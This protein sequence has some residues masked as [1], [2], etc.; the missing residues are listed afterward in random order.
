MPALSRSAFALLLALT[1][2]VCGKTS[3]DSLTWHAHVGSQPRFAA[4]H[5]RAA[6]L[7]GY[8]GYGLEAWAYPFQLFTHLHLQIV[9][10]DTSAPIDAD[11]L[12]RRI[13]Y[14]PDEIVR[15]YAGPDYEIRERLFVPLDRPG[16]I[17]SYDVQSPRPL[18]LHITFLPVLDLMWP[19]ALGGQDLH[20]NDS[21]RG[22]VI[23][24]TTTGF[25]AVIASPQAVDHTAV[26]NATL[27]QDL[28]QSM[29]LRPAGGHAEIFA[30][31][32]SEPASEGSALLTL[33]QDESQL[34]AA[35]RAQI[36]QL[37]STGLQIHTP[38][39]AL[40][41]ALIWSR[42]ALDEAWVCNER[43]GCG[44]VAGYGP[45]RPERRPQYDWF[46]AGDGLVATEGLLAAGDLARAHDELA[47]I[48]RYQNSANGMIWHEISQSAGFLDWASKYPYMYVHV[49][50]TYQFL[51]TL[52]DYYAATGDAAFLRDHWQ[53]IDAAY[54]YGRSL[55]D[56]QTALPK[57]PPDKEGG[58]EQ[59][60]MSEDVSLSAA[61]VAA[62]AA[63]HALA[64]AAGH[65]DEAAAAAAPAGA[66][67]RALT[68]RYWDPQKNFWISG[69]A[70]SGAPITDERTHPGLL[71][72]GY[73]SPDRED[74]A[75]DRLASS[76][77][78]TDWGTRGLAST[79]S[80]YDPRSYGAGSVSPL[81]TAENAGAF[82]RAHRP[83]IAESI[84]DSIL[85]WLQIDS[86]GHLHELADG[87]RF[88][89][90]VE[91]VPEQTWSSAGFLDVTV[92]GLFGLEVDAAHHELTL[93]P[94]L[95]PRWDQVS[96][97]Q[98]P[99]GP[100]QVCAAINQQAAE[101]DVAF[102]AQ[103][104][105][106]HIV[107]APEIPLGATGV[108]A[109]IDGRTAPVILEAHTEDEHARVA[110]DLAPGTARVRILFTGGLRVRV[111]EVEPARGDASRGL[112]LI[113]LHLDGRSLTL[114]A[115]IAA[116]DHASMEIQTPR[117]I[118]SVRGG[119]AMRLDGDWYRVTFDPPPAS[120]QHVCTRRSLTV[121]FP[122]R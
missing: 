38:D 48:L 20:W 25:R 89:P 45:S 4:A 109:F 43:I 22:Y 61:W 57:I 7:M 32:E 30:A 5:G 29:A 73:F 58:N 18:D 3:P 36:A 51:S 24:E 37:L 79:S 46:F 116:P 82:F 72:N 54:R 121:V 42:L 102:T 78:E 63:Y 26:V 105:P 8:T 104:A 60:R 10:R 34:R 16:V 68:A 90:Q 69:F 84:F 83:A 107:F 120:T 97:A 23:S 103:T 62:S 93:A 21:L 27:R 117:S 94:H 81:L 114:N 33:E 115:N 88:Q 31:L 17:L 99:V 53:Q 19:G 59:D 55:V 77:F 122:G 39:D 80:R 71:A 92:R 110:F 70:A 85:P 74:A 15:I 67:R 100:S 96:L 108:R 56:P 87:D 111:P 47:F 44:E 66:A 75:L 14:H 64:L 1:A 6:V 118:A 50:I 28:T 9:P 11:P 91:S 76:G 86:P 101:V 40:N 119:S 112:K 95:D 65:P 98:I 2:P 49:D 106:V 41:R 113:S 12:L 52:G 35:Y 13:E